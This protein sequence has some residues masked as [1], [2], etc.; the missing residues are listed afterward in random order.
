M[1]FDIALPNCMEGFLVPAN[2]AGPAELVRFAQEAERLGYYALWGFDF[3]APVSD[4]RGRPSDDAEPN[5]YEL[6]ISLASL[7]GVTKTIKL[8]AGVVIIPL[9]DPVILAKQSAT[10][11]QFSNGRFLL[12]LGLGGSREEFVTVRPR[13]RGAH[14][15]NML[16]EKLD[17][18]ELLLNGDGPASYS[19]KYVEFGSMELSPKPVQR[20]L[21]MYL[22]AHGEASL[23]RTAKY[24]LGPMVRDPETPTVLKSL[25]PMLEENG[26]TISDIDFCV[27]ADLRV[28]KDHDLAVK[29]YQDSTLGYFRRNIP[30]EGPGERSLDRDYGRDHRE[31]GRAKEDGRRPLHRDA[32]CYRRFP[33]HAGPVRDLRQGDHSSRREGITYPGHRQS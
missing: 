30:T 18:L 11:D 7:S 23:R 26:R 19:G 31:A 32:H 33:G 10:L 12:G 29:R 1:K 24:G 22:A 14:R 8:G 21:P 28:E 20:P 5:W 27:W 6:M 4:L 2:F 13:S 15:G 3:T 17:A 25:A 16:D 9:R